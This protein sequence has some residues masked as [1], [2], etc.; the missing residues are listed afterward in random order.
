MDFSLQLC[1]DPHP[2][3]PLASISPALEDNE[4]LYLFKRL[5]NLAL[6]ILISLDDFHAV[7]DQSGCLNPN[8]IR[9][10]GR[11]DSRVNYD[12]SRMGPTF[13]V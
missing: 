12:P 13:V 3:C 7:I 10:P 5:K 6:G 2:T 9:G 8:A 11:A 1:S 4:Q